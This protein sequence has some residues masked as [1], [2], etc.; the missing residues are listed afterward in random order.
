[1]RLIYV[2]GRVLSGPTY[3]LIDQTEHEIWFTRIEKPNRIFIVETIIINSGFGRELRKHF[4][5]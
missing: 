2:G 5:W 1:M 3:R 4:Q